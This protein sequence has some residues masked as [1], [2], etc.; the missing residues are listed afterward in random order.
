MHRGIHGLALLCLI[1]Y[2]YTD[3]TL[4]LFQRGPASVESAIDNRIESRWHNRKNPTIDNRQSRITV[5]NSFRCKTLSL[6]A[7]HAAYGLLF[8]IHTADS[9]QN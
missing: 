8:L 9:S 7:V 6:P 1:L 3:L 5:L 4:S 2:V